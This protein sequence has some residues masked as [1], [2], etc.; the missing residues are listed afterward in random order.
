MKSSITRI[1]CLLAF[2]VVAGYAVAT[3]RGP[4]GVHALFVKETQIKEM[5]IR[6][7]TLAREIERKR[8]H[9]KR[10]SD[11]SAEQELE[12]RDRLKLV[13]PTDKV[14]IIGDPAKK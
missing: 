7:T 13:N 6:N 12:I 4:R 3:L 2:L 11:N 10:L 9:I 8:E 5:E 1:A 14:Y